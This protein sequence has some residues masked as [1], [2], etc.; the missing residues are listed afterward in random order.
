VTCTLAHAIFSKCLVSKSSPLPHPYDAGNH[1]NLLFISYQNVSTYSHYI[2]INT[3]LSLE[4]KIES[5]LIADSAKTGLPHDTR[6]TVKLGIA[7]FQSVS[8]AKLLV[9]N[10]NPQRMA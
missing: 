7:E 2:S 3:V 9:A 8:G 10:A 4:I 1:G 6:P 5:G